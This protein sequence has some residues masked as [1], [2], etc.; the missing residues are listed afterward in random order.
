VTV[1]ASG[2]ASDPRRPEVWLADVTGPG[3]QALADTDLPRP[4]DRA[5]ATRM[6]DAALGRVLLARRAALRV[7]LARHL[8]REPS[9]IRVVVAPGGKPVLVPAND[10]VGG[11]TVAF[12]VAHSGNL[13]AVAVGSART[14]GLDVER[15]RTLSRALRIAERWFGAEEAERLA[16]VP[17]QDVDEAFMRLWTAKEALAKR[18]GAGLRLMKGPAVELDVQSACEEGRLAYLHVG[19]GYCAALASSE[20]VDDVQIIQPTDE[21]WTT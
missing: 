4:E 15:V 2:A 13:F 12:S 17:L 10:N 18:H 19:D 16:A 7:I 8:G 20:A 3:F 21:A 1:R 6:A 5:R 14:L 9:A 11:A